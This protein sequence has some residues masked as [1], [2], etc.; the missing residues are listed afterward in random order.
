MIGVKA[1]TGDN[2]DVAPRPRFGNGGIDTYRARTR[3]A[4]GKRRTDFIQAR[5]VGVFQTAFV[6]RATAVVDTGYTGKRA[7]SAVLPAPRKASTN[8]LEDTIGTVTLG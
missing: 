7:V 8:S 5:L 1:F 4:I 2:A 6:C 3:L